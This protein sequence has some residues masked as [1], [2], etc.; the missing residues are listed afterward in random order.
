MRIVSS[1]SAAAIGVASSRGFERDMGF[2]DRGGAAV[3]DVSCAVG[4]RGKVLC[5]DGTVTCCCAC[6]AGTTAGNCADEEGADGLGGTGILRGVASGSFS[7]KGD[8][9]FRDN[10]CVRSLS[11]SKVI[12][13]SHPPRS[14]PYAMAR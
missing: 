12:G 3:V 10:S 11:E 5:C 8:E 6:T 14:C 2:D 1:M 13:G 4:D 9:V 7:V